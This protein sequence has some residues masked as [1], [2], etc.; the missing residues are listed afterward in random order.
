MD[1]SRC[2]PFAAC[3]PLFKLIP[4]PLLALTVGGVLLGVLGM[5]G[6]PITLF[7]GLDEMKE[8]AQNVSQYSP[9]GLALVTLVKI[10]A[11]VIAA[12]S[13]FR[14]GRIF[15]S[16]F[17]GVAAGLFASSLL[18]YVPPS[19]AVAACLLG[20]LLAITRS[21]WLS[22]FMAVVVVPE[23]TLIP[24]LTIAMLPAWLLV[25]GKPEM[26]MKEVR[27]RRQLTSEF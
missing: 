9:A 15:P 20:L 14:G 25:T 13:G 26:L 4:N 12:T 8:L 21:G 3:Y 27:T 5:I 19:L 23:V 17:A 22:L 16:V 1:S 6:G 24:L 2:T 11:L 7:K 10:A 18:P